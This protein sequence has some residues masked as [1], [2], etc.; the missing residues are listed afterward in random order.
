MDV[1]IY[2]NVKLAMADGI[3][4]FKSA[5][6]VVLTRGLHDSGTIPP[7]YFASASS[8]SRDGAFTPLDMEAPV[9]V[10]ATGG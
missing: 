1:L 7:K 5:N 8:R 10:V 2:I 6:D 4:F 9:P 3:Q